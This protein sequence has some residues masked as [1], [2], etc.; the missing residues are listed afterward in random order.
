M[1]IEL[2]FTLAQG[3]NLLTIPA[4]VVD[5]SALGGNDRSR[6]S[7]CTCVAIMTGH[8]QYLKPKNLSS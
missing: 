4:T 2:L 7:M 1:H 3:T 5:G 8:M 6:G